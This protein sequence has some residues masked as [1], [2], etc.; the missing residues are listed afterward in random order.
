MSE[1]DKPT[2]YILSMDLSFL[3]G[4]V[5]NFYTIYAIVFLSP[6]AMATYKYLLLCFKASTWIFLIPVHYFVYLAVNYL[7]IANLGLVHLVESKE[8]Q[9]QIVQDYPEYT[10]LLNDSDVWR[11]DYHRKI[12]FPF[13]T[14]MEVLDAANVY[15]TFFG[16]E[17]G[18]GGA[19]AIVHSFFLL[20]E[21]RH[22]LSEKT[23]KSQK[24][25]LVALIIQ[26]F[27]PF[28]MVGIP[29]ILITILANLKIPVPQ[30]LINFGSFTLTIHGILGSVMI[31]AFAEPYREPIARLIAIPASTGTREVST[32]RMTISHINLQVEP[33]NRQSIND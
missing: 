26:T 10:Y 13:N 33:A 5:V 24:K 3:L 6:K 11:P 16:V 27:I 23:R 30:A 32:R 20:S 28:G 12:V 22:I 1:S 19:L 7:I 25:L 15:T 21:H 17:L 31:L 29:I 18:I 9:Q 4:C 8:M 14:T 2:L